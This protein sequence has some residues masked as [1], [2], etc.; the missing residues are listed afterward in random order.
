MHLLC[1][2]TVHNK[3]KKHAYYAQEMCRLCI[4]NVMLK[5]MPTML[6][7]CIFYAQETC[8]VQVYAQEMCLLYSRNVHILFRKGRSMLN[9]R[10]YDAK[11]G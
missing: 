5:N 6:K 7:K 1:L 10:I 8:L 3:L 9:K 4:Q 11:N 2:R